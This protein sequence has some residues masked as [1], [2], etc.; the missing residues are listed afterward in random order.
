[1]LLYGHASELAIRAALFLS[2]QPPGKRSTVQEVARAT[3][4]PQPYLAKILRQLTVAQLV[5]AFRGPGGGMELGRPADA[6]T[7]GAIIEAVEGR[8]RTDYCA[9]GGR[10]CTE[11]R[12]C[13]LHERWRPLC[14][15]MRRLLAET[16]LAAL[17]VP[18]GPAQGRKGCS[19]SP[20]S[21]GSV[22]PRSKQGRSLA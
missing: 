13:P 2:Q 14:E 22:A 12:P 4:L 3:Q 17:N 10:P 11:N 1:M 21:T 15:E 18:L 8:D 19:S 5:R 9:L 6:I 20:S 16:T 7:L